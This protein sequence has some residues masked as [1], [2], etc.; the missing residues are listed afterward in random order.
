M[1]FWTGFFKTAGARDAF[2]NIGN[3][4]KNFS[5]FSDDLSKMKSNISD[6]IAKLNKG[7]GGSA[8]SVAQSLN[9]ITKHIDDVRQSVTGAADS[10]RDTAKA[11]KKNLP[12]GLDYLRKGT[13]GMVGLYGG[14]KLVGVPAEYHKY[15]YY[16]KNQQLADQ[17]LRQIK[18]K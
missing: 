16:K 3:I 10:V 15:Q 11:V 5:S 14:S 9:K 6:E 12:K 17:R 18:E 1:N 13:Y 2:K 4:A 8:E 7:V